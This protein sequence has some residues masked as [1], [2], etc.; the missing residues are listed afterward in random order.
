MALDYGQPHSLL[1]HVCVGPSPPTSSICGSYVLILLS[2]CLYIVGSCSDW[3]YRV[4]SGSEQGD[5]EQ[6]RG[7]D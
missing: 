2:M 4:C 6:G 7:E 3:S 1:V 5:L